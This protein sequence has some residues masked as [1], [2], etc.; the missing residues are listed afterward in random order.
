LTEARFARALGMQPCAR[1][2]HFMLHHIAP[3]Q[4]STGA[5]Q[6]VRTVVDESVWLGLVVPKRH[7]RRAVTRNLMRR[8]MR[9]CM[10]RHVGQL[11]TGDWV[12]RLRKGFDR[13]AFPSAASDALSTLVARELDQLLER[14]RRATRR[15]GPAAS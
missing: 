13:Q 10:A 3:A 8:Q 6:V 1:S 4:L 7:A 15:S 2:D 12:M 5:E 9:A 14:A 11:P